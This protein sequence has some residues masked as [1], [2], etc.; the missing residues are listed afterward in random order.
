MGPAQRVGVRFE[1]GLV[2]AIVADINYQPGGLPL[3]QFALTELFEARENR[4][5]TQQGYQQIG[6]AVGALAKRA[7]QLYLEQSDAGREAVAPDVSAAGH[8]WVKE[9]KIRAAG[10]CARSCWPLPKMPT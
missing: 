9:A 10:W 5:L 8:G 4:I 7:E 6:G 1:D 2:A 3:L